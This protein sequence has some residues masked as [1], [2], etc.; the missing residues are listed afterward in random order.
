MNLQ[1]YDTADC[2]TEHNVY[3]CDDGEFVKYDEHE[4]ALAAKDAEITTLKAQI[5]AMKS[6]NNCNHKKERQVGCI[7]QYPEACD[8]WEAK[9]D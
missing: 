4:A 1:R 7:F 3:K 8:S 5:E 6:C 2:S 9:H